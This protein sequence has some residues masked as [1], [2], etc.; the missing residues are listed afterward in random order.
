MF[1]GINPRHA[2]APWLPLPFLLSGPLALAAAHLL[3]AARVGTVTGSYRATATIA[4]THLLV[5]GA[6]VGT[7]MGAL[8]Q[9]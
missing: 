5:L 3:L 1:G 7:M 2:P 9:M 6:I 4:V 8:Y